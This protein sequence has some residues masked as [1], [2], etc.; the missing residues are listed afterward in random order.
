MT[1]SQFKAIF[2]GL[3]L[4]SMV[5]FLSSCVAGVAYGPCIVVGSVNLRLGASGQVTIRIYGLT[6]LQS[7][8]V[9]P[10]GRFT[11]D[12]QV[13]HVKAIEG[14]SGFQVFASKIDNEKGEAH[15][16]AGYPG[17]SRSDDGVLQIVVEALGSPGSSS[18][19][20]ITMIDVLADSLGNDITD[21]EIHNGRA[22]I[23][24]FAGP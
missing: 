22:T 12:P 2:I 14:L 23:G 4:V 19:L 21:Y 6:D 7:L 18:P 17:G 9:G 15:F 24:S 11:F 8:Q 5:A 3:L 10:N 20:A 13:I 1:I 16:L